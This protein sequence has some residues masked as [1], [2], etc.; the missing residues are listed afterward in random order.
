[1]FLISGNLFG[2]QTGCNLSSNQTGPLLTSNSPP[3]PG[4]YFQKFLDLINL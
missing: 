2:I 1:M 3:A 4:T